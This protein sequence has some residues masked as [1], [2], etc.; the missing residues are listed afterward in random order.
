MTTARSHSLHSFGLDLAPQLLT[1][2]EETPG[3]R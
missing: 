1:Q 2:G 3:G